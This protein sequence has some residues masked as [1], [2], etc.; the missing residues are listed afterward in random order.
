MHGAEDHDSV[1]V[2]SAHKLIEQL[3]A[4]GNTHF[5]Y[6]EIPGMKHGP[7]SLPAASREVL[8]RA[9]LDWLLEGSRD[10]HPVQPISTQ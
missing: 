1:P 5:T 10:A 3:T 9:M 6:W 8:Q 4:A 2:E 7:D